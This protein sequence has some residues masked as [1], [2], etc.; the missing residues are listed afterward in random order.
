MMCDDFGGGEEL[1]LD[2]RAFRAGQELLDTIIYQIDKWEGLFFVVKHRE[3]V[4]E[5]IVTM[6]DISTLDLHRGARSK[7]PRGC[8]ASRTCS[9]DS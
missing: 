6:V 2:R 8:I 9:S 3:H 7:S 1:T 5:W 4:G